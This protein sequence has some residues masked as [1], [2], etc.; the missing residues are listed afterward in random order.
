MKKILSLFL[1]AG[2]LAFGMTVQEEG[3]GVDK[4]GNPLEKS[5]HVNSKA[6]SIAGE[7]INLLSYFSWNKGDVFIYIK[8]APIEATNNKTT[9][10]TTKKQNQNITMD[11]DSAMLLTNIAREEFVDR[12]ATIPTLSEVNFP[13]H[14]IKLKYKNLKGKMIDKKVDSMSGGGTIVVEIPRDYEN[15]LIEVST[16]LSG[17]IIRKIDFIPPNDFTVSKFKEHMKNKEKK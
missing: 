3:G 11:K 6:N 16:I 12:Q 1:L 17:S 7:R 4:W 14:E 13:T 15:G 2:T 10:K 8:P 5:Y 9:N